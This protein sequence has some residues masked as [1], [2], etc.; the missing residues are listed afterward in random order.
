VGH[1]EERPA[2]LVQSP[3]VQPIEIKGSGLAG[4]QTIRHGER[5]RKLPAH[6]DDF[7]CYS[8]RFEEPISIA[9]PLQK[10]SSDTHYPI[11]HYVTCANFSPSHQKFTVAITKS[12]EPRFYHEAVT[13]T[14]WRK[15]MA[16]EIQTLE[17]N[18]TWDIVDL[19]P[20]KKAISG[21]WVYRVKYNS[22]GTIQCYKARLVIRGDIKSKDLT[23]MKHLLR[24]PR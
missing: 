10:G 22:D 9:A 20:D 8:A 21:K 15:A 16:V 19:L 7:A 14:Q 6:L 13:D 2:G 17:A 11:I 4:G 18:E 12:I 3:A 1:E 24:L 5:V 23:S